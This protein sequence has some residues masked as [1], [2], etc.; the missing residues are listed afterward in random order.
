MS[1]LHSVPE[2]QK[3][4]LTASE[5]TKEEQKQSNGE[6]FSVHYHHASFVIHKS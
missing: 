5:T 2:T 3:M 1:H 4:I 6:L